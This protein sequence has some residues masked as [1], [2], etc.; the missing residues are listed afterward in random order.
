MVD[1]VTWN[2]DNQIVVG[3][4]APQLSRLSGPAPTLYPAYR[5]LLPNFPARSRSL[6]HNTVTGGAGRTISQAAKLPDAVAQRTSR[7]A[8]RSSAS[9]TAPSGQSI[10]M[11][12][13]NTRH[14]KLL[15]YGMAQRATNRLVHAA[16]GKFPGFV[17]LRFTAVL[18]RRNIITLC[19]RA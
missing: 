1:C 7:M 2:F 9:R 3:N 17:Y 10:L 14:V 19:D 16:S 12:Q 18:W 8:H 13:N 6:T 4:A 5:L 15:V 11:R